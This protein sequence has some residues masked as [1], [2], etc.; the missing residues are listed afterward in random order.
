MD[1]HVVCRLLHLRHYIRDHGGQKM[2]KEVTFALAVAGCIFL[3]VLFL[4]EFYTT[5]DKAQGYDYLADNL[6]HVGIEAGI[7][8][9]LANG[10]PQSREELD[11]A[12][13]YAR[14]LIETLYPEIKWHWPPLKSNG[15]EPRGEMPNAPSSVLIDA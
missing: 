14:K 4:A 6:A 12:R 10:I 7:N 13:M 1:S 2:K 9:I 3:V 11:Q 8:A 5:R 15:A